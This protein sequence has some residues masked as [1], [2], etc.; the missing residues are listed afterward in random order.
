MFSPAGPGNLPD[1]DFLGAQKLDRCEIKVFCRALRLDWPGYPATG[2][3]RHCLAF[4]GFTVPLEKETEK[5]MDEGGLKSMQA[6]G[7]SRLLV[8]SLLVA[9]LCPGDVAE[10]ER[11]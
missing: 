10:R 5:S 8:T 11:K 3:I 1:I 9:L 2:C 7:L 6:D 4:E